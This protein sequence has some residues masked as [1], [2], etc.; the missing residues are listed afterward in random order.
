[1]PLKNQS[2]NILIYSPLQIAKRIE[3]MTTKCPNCGQQFTAVNKSHY[4]FG[5]P[6]KHALVWK[7]QLIAVTE[8]SVY[9]YNGKKWVKIIVPKQLINNQMEEI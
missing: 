1:M 7:D 6:I 8:S 5:E 9:G 2:I 4:D 3:S